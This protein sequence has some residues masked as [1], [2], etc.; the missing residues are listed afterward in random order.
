MLETK[1]DN[2]ANV[3]EDWGISQTTLEEVIT[4]LL[5]MIYRCSSKLLDS[6]VGISLV[7]CRCQLTIWLTIWLHDTALWIMVDM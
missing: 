2:K 7:S 1:A 5:I 4:M 6:S 3:I